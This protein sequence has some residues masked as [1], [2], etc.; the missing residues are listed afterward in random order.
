MK[1]KWL[2]PSAVVEYVHP[3][4]RALPEAERTTW[5]LGYITAEQYAEV[6]DCVNVREESGARASRW[7][8]YTLRLLRFGLRGWGGGGA[9]PFAVDADG[10]VSAESLSR[11]PGTMR[12]H[13]ANVLDAM[14]SLG[15]D[16]VKA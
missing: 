14:N 2:D 16:A 7:G 8:T 1:M 15:S 3:E 9:P 11:I 5:R 13:L 4:E 6:A 12:T 10:F